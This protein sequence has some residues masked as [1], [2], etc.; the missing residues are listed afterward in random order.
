MVD[1][2]RVQSADALVVT[3]R[4]LQDALHEDGRRCLAAQDRHLLRSQA[5]PAAS[6]VAAEI[7]QFVQLHLKV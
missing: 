7:I 2:Q 5:E 6:Y 3:T 4:Q 1:E